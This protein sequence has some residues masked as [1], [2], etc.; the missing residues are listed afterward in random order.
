MKDHDEKQFTITPMSPIP[1]GLLPQGV[2]SHKVEA[3]LFDIY[4][5]LFI[6]GSGNIGIAEKNSENAYKLNPLFQKFSIKDPVENVLKNYFN[7]IEKAHALLRSK[8]VDFPEIR[9]EEIWKTVLGKNNMENIHDFS[10]EYEMCMNP[11]FPMPNVLETL[12]YCR[13]KN[14]WMGIISNAQFYTPRLFNIFFS[15]DLDS[16]GFDRDLTFFSY[17]SGYA[18]PSSFLFQQAVLRLA[19]NKI[20]PESV[21]YVG[22]DMLNDI[23][24]AQKA[25]FQTALF[26]GDKRSLRLRNDD[27]RCKNLKPD[28]VIT[29]LIQLLNYIP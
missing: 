14:V 17:Q 22:N 2:L 13:D 11:V 3:V 29:D 1:T 21:I 10:I 16:L 7:E 25:G 5:T 8:G 26:A 15:A 4:G 19:Q 20:S 12:D 28:L 24:P 6:S 27:P 9:I 18:K 23:Y